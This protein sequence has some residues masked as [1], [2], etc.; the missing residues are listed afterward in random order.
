[1]QE[2]TGDMKVA[3]VIRRWPETVEVFRGRGCQDVG[4]GLTP[5][6]M[7][8]RNAA[9]MEAIDLASLLEDLNKATVRAST[10]EA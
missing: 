5:R 10:Q 2:I 9:R 6:L 8:V 4:G 3:E 7:T 1:M